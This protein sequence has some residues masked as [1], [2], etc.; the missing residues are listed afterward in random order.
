MADKYKIPAGATAAEYAQARFGGPTRLL[1]RDVTIGTAAAELLQNNPRRV[2]WLAQ[3][4]GAN[5]ISTSNARDVTTGVGFLLA[6]TGGA[7]SMEV[8]ED[9]EAV[10]YDRYAISGVAGN[11]VHVIEVIRV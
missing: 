10:T 11:V 4:R 1:E 2:A 5:D 8:D 6:A 9:G 3:N 7:Q